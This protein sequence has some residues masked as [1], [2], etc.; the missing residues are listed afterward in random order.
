LVGYSLGRF[1]IEQLRT[2]QLKI[3]GTDI[4]VSVVLSSCIFTLCVVMII[5]GRYRAAQRA[6]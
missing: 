4:G 3:P 2:D 5:A 6:Q 1:F